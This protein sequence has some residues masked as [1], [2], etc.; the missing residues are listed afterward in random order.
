MKDK[1]TFGLLFL[2]GFVLG[3]VLIAVDAKAQNAGPVSQNEPGPYKVTSSIEV[4]VRGVSVNGNADKFRSDLNYQPGIRLFDSSFLMESKGN[5]EPKLF[6]TLLVNSSGWGGDPSGYFRANVDKTKY[7]RFDAS[8]RRFDYFN[9][10]RTFALNQH[11]ADTRHTMGDFD[12]TLLPRNEHVKFLVGYSMDRSHGSTVTTYDYQRDEYP[13]LAPTEREGNDYRVGVD[14]R[15]GP[16]DLSFQ[17]GIR[18]FKED[19]SYLIDKFQIGNNP[20]NSAVLSSF[21]RDMPTRGRI[22]Y[23][24]LSLHSLVEK[25][26][27][28]TGRFIYQSATTRYTLLETATGVDGSNNKIVLDT[29]NVGGDTKRTNGIGDLGV[30]IA[31]TDKLRISDTVRVNAFHI[32]GGDRLNEVLLRSRTTAGVET[33]LPP[34][35]VDTLSFRT[36][37]SRRAV[38]TIE[39]DYDFHPQFSAHVG[40]RYTDRHIE[41]DKL[42]VTTGVPAP[43]PGEPEV[44]NNRTNTYIVGFRARP[45]KIWT[46]YFDF[47]KGGADNVFTR[48]DNYDFTN[49]RVR[50]ILRP[51]GKLAINASVITKDNNNPS[52]TDALTLQNFGVNVNSRVYSASVDWSPSAKFSLDSGYT[53][54]HLTSDAVIVFFGPPPGGTASVRTTGLSRYFV[55]DEYAYINT[56]V[57]L[58]PRASVYA[59]YRMHRDRG[60]GNRISAPDVLIGSYPIQFSSPEVRL[61][62]RLHDRVDWNFGYQ[63]FDFKERFGNSQFYQAHLPYTSLRIYFGRG[64]D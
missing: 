41:L 35:L 45:V 10:L 25:K 30:T 8:V 56:S 24:R 53:H 39:I 12:L 37:S 52:L 27:D 19:T 50:S 54:T 13:I 23:T 6:D 2:L 21:R 64:K 16:L 46:T 22:P 62:V 43:A 36:T 28:F 58:H 51:T 5:G 20:I 40:H 31:A 3:I 42:A 57:Q 59:G 18:Y 9:S 48:V 61:A 44:F 49:V 32:D 29:F 47:E 15:V 14:A 4:G 34:L 11:I 38:N 60:Q 26:V 1:T 63:Y 55:R 7:Y 33:A 17:Q